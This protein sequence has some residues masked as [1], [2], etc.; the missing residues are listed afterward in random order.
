M[1]VTIA[2]MTQIVRVRVNEQGRVVLPAALRSR[3]GI[4]PGDTV[5]VILHDD[6]LEIATPEALRDR[7]WARLEPAPGAPFASDELIAE[8]RAE[9]AREEA[10]NAG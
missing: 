9:A 5:A 2:T 1:K 6:H 3:V 8:R 10:E 4:K 7:V